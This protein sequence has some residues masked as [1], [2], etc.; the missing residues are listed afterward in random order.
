MPPPKLVGVG[1]KVTLVPLHIVVVPATA[2]G[3][4]AM[5]TEGVTGVVPVPVTVFDTLAASAAETVIVADFAPAEAGVNVT[6][7]VAVPPDAA[8]VVEDNPLTTN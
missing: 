3:L 5:L 2:A 4:E 1:V 7:Y 8:I 6:L